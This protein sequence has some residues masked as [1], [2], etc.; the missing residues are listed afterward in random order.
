MEAPF[1]IKG[2]I[3]KNGVSCIWTPQLRPRSGINIFQERFYKQN[4]IQTKKLLPYHSYL[5]K[6]HVEDWVEIH[7]AKGNL[8][9]FNSLVPSGNLALHFV[10]SFYS[11][12]WG[13]SF[14]NVTS[15]IQPRS[16]MGYHEV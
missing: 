8:M 12:V 9:V 7:I 13:K 4:L 10:G 1:S 14:Q 11:D 5:E 6:K 3:R 2:L 16:A 15:G